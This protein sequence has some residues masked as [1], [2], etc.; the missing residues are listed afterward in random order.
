MDAPSRPTGC[1]APQWRHPSRHPTVIKLG[2]C[3]SYAMMPRLRAYGRIRS[4]GLIR[5][6]VSYFSH[7]ARHLQSE[8]DVTESA[9]C[10]ELSATTRPAKRACDALTSGA[11]EDCAASTG[12]LCRA[13]ANGRGPDLVLHPGVEAIPGLPAFLLRRALTTVSLWTSLEAAKPLDKFLP[14]LDVGKPFIV[15]SI[16]EGARAV[17]AEPGPQPGV[18]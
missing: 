14:M 5:R 15:I 16:H 9:H 7:S 1:Y 3:F 10:L 17:G 12:V 13:P 4:R 11:R 2:D 18:T 6:D 8:T